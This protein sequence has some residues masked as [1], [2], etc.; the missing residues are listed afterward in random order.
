MG[1]KKDMVTRPPTF[2]LPEGLMPNLYSPAIQPG[3][4]VLQGR[5]GMIDLAAVEG[6]HKVQ[7]IGQVSC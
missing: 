1:Q 4:L 5:F 3:P 2:L 7:M 6:R